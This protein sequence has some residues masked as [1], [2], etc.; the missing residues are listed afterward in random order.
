MMVRNLSSWRWPG[1]GLQAEFAGAPPVGIQDRFEQQ[2]RTD[3]LQQMDI[4][5]D[6]MAADE[7]RKV[8]LGRQE[9]DLLEKVDDLLVVGPDQAGVAVELL[10]QRD[11]HTEVGG[12]RK[13]GQ[14][15]SL[16]LSYPPRLQ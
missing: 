14:F 11:Q 12:F 5:N 6:A 9:L 15:Q 10:G 8:T 13:L 1:L 16:D 4:W 3:A 2:R 7:S